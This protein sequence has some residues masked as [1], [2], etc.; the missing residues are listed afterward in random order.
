MAANEEI[1]VT[2]GASGKV[3]RALLSAEVLLSSLLDHASGEKVRAKDGVDGAKLAS[4]DA[5]TA[6]GRSLTATNS[7]VGLGERSLLPSQL[8][9]ILSA[10]QPTELVS[11][12]E[13][14]QSFG[15]I[16]ILITSCIHVCEPGCIQLCMWLLCQTL[17]CATHA[18]T[19]TTLIEMKSR[20]LSVLL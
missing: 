19:H 9:A 20:H 12:R 7:L 6:A 15:K 3:S 16:M 4:C 14:L 1:T 18:R 11:P 17:H 13:T 2:D 8:S 10:S 5:E